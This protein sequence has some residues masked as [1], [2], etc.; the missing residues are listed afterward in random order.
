MEKDKFNFCIPSFYKNAVTKMIRKVNGPQNFLFISLRRGRNW[1]LMFC[2]FMEFD[3]MCLT[4]ARQAIYAAALQQ[5]QYSEALWKNA[6]YP[7]SSTLT[8]QAQS[9]IM[10][11]SFLH[12]G[13]QPCT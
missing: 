7:R 12:R 8:L 4:L 6:V 9:T 5:R 10:R 3:F 1:R 11:S 2:Q 13:V